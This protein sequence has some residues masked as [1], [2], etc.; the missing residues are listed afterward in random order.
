MRRGK[1]RWTANSN[2]GDV[3]GPGEQGEPAGGGV[4]EVEYDNDAHSGEEH[5]VGEE[6]LHRA[7]YLVQCALVPSERLSPNA[8]ARKARNWNWSWSAR[9]G[10]RARAAS[11]TER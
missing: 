4:D 6:L 10:S 5:E 3:D 7:Q 11:E 2:P 8:R 9:S 1:E